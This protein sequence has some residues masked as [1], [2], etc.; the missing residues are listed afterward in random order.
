MSV[1]FQVS[2]N[3]LAKL[4]P[5]VYSSYVFNLWMKNCSKPMVY[6]LLQIER[7]VVLKNMLL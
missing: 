5:G 4:T 7:S 1:N 3:N 6:Y 2:I